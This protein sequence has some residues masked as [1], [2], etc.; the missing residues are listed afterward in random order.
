MDVRTRQAKAADYLLSLPEGRPLLSRDG[1]ESNFSPVPLVVVAAADL[2]VGSE[3]I[4]SPGRLGV[5]LLTVSFGG[6]W[7]DTPIVENASI[8]AAASG[9]D[10]TIALSLLLEIVAIFSSRGRIKTNSIYGPLSYPCRWWSRG[11][12]EGPF[13][14]NHKAVYY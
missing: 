2:P 5:V 14:K 12:V 6:G 10:I 1:P 3:A 9:R 13:L 7:A 4:L 11:R 8:K